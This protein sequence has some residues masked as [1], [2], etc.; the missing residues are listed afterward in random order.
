MYGYVTV[1]SQKKYYYKV[2]RGSQLHSFGNLLYYFNV[3][4]ALL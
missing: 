2:F 3:L 4:S 1:Y